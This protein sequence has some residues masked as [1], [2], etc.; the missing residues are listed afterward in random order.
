MRKLFIIAA[1]ASSMLT[2]GCAGGGMFEIKQAIEAKPKIFFS[3]LEDGATVGLKCFGLTCPKLRTGQQYLE[4]APMPT[5]IHSVNKVVSDALSEALEGAD[6]TTG[7]V[8][9]LPQTTTFGISMPSY[10]GTGYGMH[11][12]LGVQISFTAN[13]RGTTGDDK[14]YDVTGVTSLYIKAIDAEGKSTILRPNFTGTYTLATARRTGFIESYSDKD[15]SSL[16]RNSAVDSLV[17]ELKEMSKQ[18]VVRFVAE[19]KAAQAKK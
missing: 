5:Y 11:I 3:G 14:S 19:M 4:T 9:D 16:A 17:K 13:R 6:I 8:N 15:L 7:S 10:T 12:Q 1:L 2:A 18:G